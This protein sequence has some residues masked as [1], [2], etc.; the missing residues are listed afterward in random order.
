MTSKLITK[1][2]YNMPSNCLPLQV[3]DQRPPNQIRR[4]IYPFVSSWA[5]SNWRLRDG[6]GGDGVRRLWVEDEKTKRTLVLVVKPHAPLAMVVRG[7]G[8]GVMVERWRQ[9]DEGGVEMVVWPWWR[10]VVWWQQW[11]V[12]TR[13]C[14][15]QRGG[16]GCGDDGVDDDGVMVMR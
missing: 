15:R 8:V 9:G 2:A 3:S 10:R 4:D 12:V 5:N 6:G 16:V 13:W 7:D 11:K 1:A 14:R